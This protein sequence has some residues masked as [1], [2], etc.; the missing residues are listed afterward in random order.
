MEHNDSKDAIAI[1]QKRT[2]FIHHPRYQ[3]LYSQ[4]KKLWND[5]SSDDIEQELWNKYQ[6]ANHFFYIYHHVSLIQQSSTPDGISI[7]VQ[8]ND[9]ETLIHHIK[10]L[11]HSVPCTIS[12]NST[13][14][15]M[16]I[17]HVYAVNRHSFLYDA[18]VHRKGIMECFEF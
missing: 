9:S 6:L 16:D 3:A 5:L 15:T 14:S 17:I 1:S 18:L 13:T 11:C 12:T 10:Q 2:K 7:K 4:Y 8:C